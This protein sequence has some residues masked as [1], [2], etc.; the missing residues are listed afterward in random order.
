MR[1]IDADELIETLKENLDDCDI[2]KDLEIFGVYD[3][4]EN[5]PTAFDVEKVVK[6]VQ[7]IGTRFCSSVD[8]N[9]E[10]SDCDHGSIMR[11]II[12]EVRKGGID[13]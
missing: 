4:I 2:Q 6:N 12:D 13:G 11:T 8:C 1:L 7:N 9:N 3:F 10:C 5:Q